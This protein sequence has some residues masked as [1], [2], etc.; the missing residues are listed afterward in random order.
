MNNNLISIIVP[1][2]NAQ[3]HLK[4]CLY[5]ILNQTYKN[6]ELILIN[7]GSTDKSQSI[8]QEII[9][10]NPDKNI[11]YVFQ[12]NAG[13]SIVRNKGI[14][15]ANGTYLCFVDADD[16]MDEKALVLMYN[17]M[18]INKVDL[19]CA[20]YY[21]C[22]TRFPK[23]LALHDFALEKQ[24]TILD[25]EDY[26]KNLF[27]GV[28]GVL[29]AKLFKKEIFI[30]HS[31]QLNPEIRLSEDLLV[32]IAYS[33][34][35]DKVYILS[36]KVYYYNRIGEEGLSR[37]IKESNFKDLQ[38]TNRAILEFK[39]DLAQLDLNDIIKKREIQFI[40]HF[41]KQNTRSYAAFKQSVSF[42]IDNFEENILKAIMNKNKLPLWFSFF[43]KKQ[44]Y[45]SYLLLKMEDAL[46]KGKRLIKK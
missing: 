20:G 10:E 37:N 18:Q 11:Q 16:Y 33:K 42:I 23:G 29:W 22:N 30:K 44:Y 3:K 35:V 27:K 40:I 26:Q 4:K 38:L 45:W 46:R 8:I 41:L 31:I 14:S 32:V 34:Y 9:K 25:K 7:D 6:W 21:E 39:E 28:S 43:V 17:A 15:L 2:Y 1:I 5:S 19:V 36:D 13:P 12:E 24:N